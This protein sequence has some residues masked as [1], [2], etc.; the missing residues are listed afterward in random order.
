MVRRILLAHIVGAYLVP[1]LVN[2]SLTCVILGLFFRNALVGSA[3]EGLHMLDLLF[4]IPR[5]L[6][7]L[8]TFLVT[9][10]PPLNGYLITLLL[11]LIGHGLLL[12]HAVPRS[13]PRHVIQLG[14]FKPAAGLLELLL[15]LR[16]QCI[17]LYEGLQ[18]ADCYLLEVNWVETDYRL[19]VTTISCSLGAE[20]G[21][22]LTLGVAGK[23]LVLLF[24]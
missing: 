17:V 2:W 9:A 4:G 12:N 16:L 23:V 7:G 5:P 24:L 8:L 21:C 1:D 15:K 19:G 6:L 22:T 14:H 3:L 10:S 13:F 18:Q 11:L 20:W